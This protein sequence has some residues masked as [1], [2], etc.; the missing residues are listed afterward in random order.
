M[1]SDRTSAARRVA[2]R[3][4]HRVAVEEAWATPAL[5]AEIA[6]ARLDRRDAALAT[7]ITY[8]ALRVLPRL[9]A[10]VDAHLAKP[11]KT[12]AY[13]RAALRAAAY[14][15]LHLSRVPSHAAVS[16][17]VALV[18]NERG[19][20][21]AGVA[22]AV[23]R[24]VASARPEQPAPPDRIEVPSWVSRAF[25]RALGDERAKAFLASRPLPPPLGLRAVRSRPDERLAAIRSARPDAEAET[26]VLA[27]RGL[28]VR[29]AGDPRAL[30]GYAEGLLAVQEIG[31]QL[32][33]GLVGEGG[34]VADLCAG[35][36]TKSLALVERA[37]AVVAVDLYEE[38]LE[39]AERE[40][41]RLGLD[42]AKLETRAV[43]LTVGTGGL[44]ASFDRVLVDAPC[45]GL[46]TLHRR[47]ELLLRLGPGDPARLAELQLA[48]LANAAKLVRPGGLLVYAVCSPTAEEGAGVVAR[49]SASH[50]E[51]EVVTARP[52]DAI[53]ADSDGIVRIGP[54]SGETAAPDAY[55]VVRWTKRSSA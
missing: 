41:A 34:R 36:G 12:D 22:N 30:P 27:S 17:A 1:T 43:D 46:G 3:V 39:R 24:K 50:P 53:A 6:R 40:R 21:L 45:T 47:P 35:H 42:P 18:K 28:W 49:F 11:S 44:D 54:W 23:L 37:E 8:G 14:Q 31:S 33:V 2:T 55:Q 7:E 26:C 13:L 32:V 38:K 19:P 20:R 51:F 29:G 15:I 48:I 10:A 9:D 16:D 52:R 4:L 25:E 5:D